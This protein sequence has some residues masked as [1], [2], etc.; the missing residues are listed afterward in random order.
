MTLEE[1]GVERQVDRLRRIAC[2]GV[3]GDRRE[4]QRERR[5]DQPAARTAPWLGLHRALQDLGHV[6]ES[7]GV[8]EPRRV[9]DDRALLVRDLVEQPLQSARVVVSLHDAA[10]PFSD[11]RSSFSRA[12]PR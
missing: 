12:M 10:S 6:R 11:S 1:I 4:E 7:G 8:G 3:A 9:V 2:R 5:R